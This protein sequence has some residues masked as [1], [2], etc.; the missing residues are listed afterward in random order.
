MKTMEYKSIEKTM[1]TKRH[2][3]FH[4]CRFIY[5]FLY[6]SSWHK[7]NMKRQFSHCENEVQVLMW[8]LKNEKD[9]LLFV[10]ERCNLSKF[11]CLLFS[12]NTNYQTFIVKIWNSP[13]NKTLSLSPSTAK[14]RLSFKNTTFWLKL[15]FCSIT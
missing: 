6:V 9:K 8:I 15:I 7:R 4:I 10:R 3:C 13:P 12:L 14:T 5:V 11:T 1:N 2:M